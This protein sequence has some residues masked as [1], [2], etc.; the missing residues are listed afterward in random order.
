VPRP[1]PRRPNTAVRLSD[2]QLGALD[3]IAKRRRVR[4][5]DIIR[6]AID[7]YLLGASGRRAHVDRHPEEME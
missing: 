4:R 3:D 5:S 2:K 7:Q 6:E 1:G